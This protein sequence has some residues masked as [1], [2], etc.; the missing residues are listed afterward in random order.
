MAT[1]GQ[2]LSTDRAVGAIPR[3]FVAIELPARTRSAL[4]HI[5]TELR[6]TGA[7]AA[8]VPE[9]NLHMT[10][11]FIGTATADRLATIGDLVDAIAP[12]IA[13]FD[14]ELFGLGIFGRPRAP[15]TIWAGVRRRP[16]AAT[17]LVE[18]LGG[19]LYDHGIAVDRSP[20]VP[21]VTLA[22][23]RSPAGIRSILHA[24][25]I[26]AHRPI[27]DAIRV[28]HVALMNS[29]PTPDGVR[30]V[31]LHRSSLGTAI[32]QTSSVPEPT[33]RG[34]AIADRPCDV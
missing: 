11:L 6:T 8:W 14:V 19:A 17:L 20:F 7:C 1:L 25:R 12:T 16:E 13:P 23:I 21:H 27:A 33:E 2:T 22:R 29:L 30:Y 26:S 32:P 5:Q 18:R 28:R 34:L 10:L 9:A 4:A 15:R 24:L 3:L 31:K